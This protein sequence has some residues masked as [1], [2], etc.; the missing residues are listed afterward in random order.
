MLNPN[1][2]MSSW[3]TAQDLSTMLE[4]GD[5]VEF[6]RVLRRAAPYIHW[7]VYIGVVDG[8][9]CL[10]HLSTETSD[11]G[12]DTKNELATKIVSGCTAQV[13]SDPFFQVAGECLC[14]INNTLDARERPFPPSI[15]TERAIQKLGQGGYNVLFNNCEHFAKWCRYGAR[16]SEQATYIQTAIIGATAVAVSGGSLAVGVAA[17]TAGYVLLRAGRAFHRRF[18]GVQRSII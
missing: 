5:L 4:L 6:S 8:V 3:H 12:L 18:P 2:L 1:Q 7:G 16:E 15:I 10:A 17:G 9:Q 11:L 13:R 14:R